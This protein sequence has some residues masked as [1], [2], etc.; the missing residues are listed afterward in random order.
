VVL[1]EIVRWA[2][3]GAAGVL[4]AG[5]TTASIPALKPGVPLFGALAAA[6]G[7]RLA[8]AA[9][10]ILAVAGAVT[11]ARDDGAAGAA[12]G[13]GGEPRTGSGP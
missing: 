4:N 9:S 7:C 2:P 11:L 12:R 6:G 10:T 8:F 5:Q 13:A 3:A 1:A